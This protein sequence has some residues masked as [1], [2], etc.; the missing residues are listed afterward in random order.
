MHPTQP[1][2]QVTPRGFSHLQ[3]RANNRFLL[4]TLGHGAPFSTS[5]HCPYASCCSRCSISSSLLPGE[6][7]RPLLCPLLLLPPAEPSRRQQMDMK[8]TLATPL[9]AWHTCCA[10]WWSRADAGGA[11]VVR[12][13]H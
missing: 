7:S 1:P 5:C 9:P 11:V 3:R 13:S 2:L 4:V 10:Q 8:V 12:S 6:A